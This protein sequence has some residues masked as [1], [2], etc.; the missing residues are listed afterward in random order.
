[1]NRTEFTPLFE[2]DELLKNEPHC[3]N[4]RAQCIQFIEDCKEHAKIC[5]SGCHRTCKCTVNKQKE[6]L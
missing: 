6:G 1:M 5:F 4:N 2:C 3:H